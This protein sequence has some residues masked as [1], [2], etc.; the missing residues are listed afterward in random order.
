L[1][2]RDRIRTALLAVAAAALVAAVLASTSGAAE[3]LVD[4]YTGPTLLASFKRVDGCVTR[5]T[6]LFAFSDRS[7]RSQ[8][9]T[10]DNGAVYADFQTFDP[11]GAGRREHI[12]I[13]PLPR[14]ALHVDGDLET[15]TLRGTYPF[16]DSVRNEWASM[17]LDLAWS[18][19][20][21]LW[22]DSW[23]ARTGSGALG[24]FRLFDDT[25]EHRPAQASGSVFDGVV[26][27]T[28]GASLLG[29]EIDF[30]RV[31]TIAVER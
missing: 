15:A 18:A 21:P 5:Q 23:H 30:A 27:W 4:R 8:I 22:I 26:D 24:R 17:T 20:G 3:V 9:G 28:S 1:R 31:G 10:M 29:A 7:T 13:V 25:L 12:A 11:C 14:G 19:T 2:R 6:D 16:W